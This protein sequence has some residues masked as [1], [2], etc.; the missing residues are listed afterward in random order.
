MNLLMKWVTIS[1]TLIFFCLGSMSGQTRYEL[2]FQG[3]LADIEGTAIHEDTF[4]LTV[5]LRRINDREVRF[6]FTSEAVTDR[7]GWFGFNIDNV[8][9]FM[10]E[11]D[12]S[13]EPIVLQMEFMPNPHTDW[14]KEGNDFLVTYLIEPSKTDDA[15]FQMTRME[16]SGL[17]V[18]AETHLHAFRDIYPFAYLKG[19]FLITDRPPVDSLSIADLRQ[20]MTPEEEDTSRGIK[21][22]FPVGGYRKKK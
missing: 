1:G 10:I 13:W 22:G 7:E 20:W 4:T 12:G 5:S 2:S 15:I 3:H 17:D 6:R 19:G 18:Y 16:G 14:M 11:E 8:A 9:E 21:G